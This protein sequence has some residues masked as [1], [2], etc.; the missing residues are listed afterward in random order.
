[1]KIEYSFTYILGCQ[2]LL[3][4]IIESSAHLTCFDLQNV[5]CPY[6]LSTFLGFLKLT[7]SVQICKISA[8]NDHRIRKPL[9]RCVFFMPVVGSRK[10]LAWSKSAK[11]GNIG[12]VKVNQKNV[13]FSGLKFWLWNPKDF[14]GLNPPKSLHQNLGLSS[15]YHFVITD[16]LRQSS[17]GNQNQKWIQIPH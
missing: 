6:L 15:T 16:W 2:M 4:F 9:K 10:L 7:S 17:V 1:M 5:F 14:L 12:L 3:R 11:V 13:S 8:K